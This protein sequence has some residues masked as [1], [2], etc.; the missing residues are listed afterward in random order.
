MQ[1]STNN[2]SNRDDRLQQIAAL[3][4]E[5]RAGKADWGAIARLEGR[6]CSKG[7]ANTFLICCLL[8]WQQDAD[9][10]WE[11]GENLVKQ[12]GEESRDPD[13]EKLWKTISS[14]SKDKWDSKYEYYGK[15]HRFR[16]GY[17]RLWGIA[18][19]M[20]ARY[21]GDARNIWLGKTPFE[22]L[23]H[24][25]AL[26]AGDQIS[27]MVVGALRDCGQIKGDS[28]DVKADGHLRRVLGRA[29][30]NEEI[31]GAN[32]AKVTELTRQLNPADPWQLDWPLWNVGKY[33]CK[34]TS[35]D[36]PNCYLRPHCAYYRLHG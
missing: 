24:L 1:P 21:D 7:I 23:I 14:S 34:P 6:E 16:K 4:L 12:L 11:K 9:V 32:A 17:T 33:Y 30:Y 18:N 27:R 29:V 35:P 8:D 28:G 5:H 36:C 31:S 20:C 19:D 10:A 26:G 15:P 3:L 2:E 13:A 25:W 22:A